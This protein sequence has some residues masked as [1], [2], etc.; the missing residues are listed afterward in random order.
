MNTVIEG[1]YN[2][3]LVALS[4]VIAVIASYTAL[5]LAGRVKASTGRA[6]QIWAYGGA[7]SM[8]TGIWSMHFIGM[9]AFVLPM[10]MGYDIPLT[11]V[12]MLVAVLASAVALKVINTRAMGRRRLQVGGIVMGLGICT[13]HYV[14]MAAMI[15]DMD[16]SYD[17]WLFTASVAIAIGASIAALWLAFRLNPAETDSRQMAPTPILY[18]LMVA[19]VMG[20]AIAGMH[21]T[22]MAAAQFSALSTAVMVDVDLMSPLQ[23]ALIVA[24]V[25]TFIMLITLALSLYDAHLASR[26]AELAHSLQ[27]ANEELQ[28]MVMHDQLTRLPNRLLLEDRIRQAIARAK[29]NKSEFAVLFIDLDK[30]KTVNDSLGHHIGDLLIQEAAARLQA[31]VREADTVARVGGDEF[32]VVL[33]DGTTENS[34][35]D[36]V[37]RM[38]GNM[39]DA[40]LIDGHEIRISV[41]VGV[42]F[43]PKDGQDI[44]ELMVRSDAAMYYAKEA[45]RNNYQFFEPGMISIAGQRNKLENKLRDALARD[46]LDLAFQ[47]KI[48]V[49]TGRIVGVE[50][51][52]RWHDPELG[53]ISPDE[54][55]PIAEGS[56]LILPLGE[57]VLRTACRQAREW[58]DQGLPKMR[59]AV[60]LS[61]YQLNQQSFIDVVKRALSDT[62]LQARY[63]ELEITE[64]AVMQNP[65]SARGLL[66]ELHQMGVRISI[67]DFGTGYSNLSQ[68]KSFP[69]DSLKIDRSFTSGVTSCTQDA[70]IVRAVMAL[71]HS[72]NLEVIAEGVETE[73]Q[74]DFIRKLEG[75]QYQGYLCSKPLPADKF[76]QFLKNRVNDVTDQVPPEES[77]VTNM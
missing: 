69:I 2:L 7:F 60:N 75:Q 59:I 61:A 65:R 28:A 34:A 23:L 46:A 10:P 26:T 1:T 4:Y 25:S 48:D 73:G 13:M 22:G 56:G 14:G 68:L 45:G 71:A 43:Y 74:L 44:H 64:S 17:P 11:V 27:I 47:P 8:G 24:V 72:L 12:S 54:F 51:L 40:F 58:Q 9:L 32:M 55:I 19:A 67:D 49:K 50:S 38:V 29:R 62:G 37:K 52:A 41:S 21:Y 5:D 31:S 42:S 16:I 66:N 63:L 76:G 70:A 39:I 15:M 33:A 35:E 18:R 20:I 77:G 3:P 57:W 36:V 30:F 6:R 53:M